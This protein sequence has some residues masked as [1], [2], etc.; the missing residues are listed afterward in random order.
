MCEFLNRAER[1]IAARCP[2]L[3][4]LHGSRMVL[5]LRQFVAARHA[6]ERTQRTTHP[7]RLDARRRNAAGR[8]PYLDS[9]RGQASIA[10]SS[11]HRRA[12]IRNR[13]AGDVTR[14][15]LVTTRVVV[16]AAGTRLRLLADFP[17]DRW[18]CRAEIDME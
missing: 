1:P 8:S 11:L 17:L 15:R 4:R 10:S 18:I 14:E 7:D 2:L 6:S 9:L 13:Y 16:P 5:F 3:E 12:C